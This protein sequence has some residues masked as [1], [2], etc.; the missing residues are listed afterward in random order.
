MNAP[1]EKKVDIMQYVVIGLAIFVVGVAISVVIRRRAEKLHNNLV[2]P[3]F[4]QRRRN[5]K[6]TKSMNHLVDNNNEHAFFLR[7]FSTYQ[8]E[9]DKNV[10]NGRPMSR[11]LAERLQSLSDTIEYHIEQDIKQMQSLTQNVQ[12]VLIS[13]HLE[14]DEVQRKIKKMV[15]SAR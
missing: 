12:E 5:A 8:S 2:K 3:N 14:L 11:A 7:Q 13:R 9:Y 10:A 4:R 6:A 15:K 1:E